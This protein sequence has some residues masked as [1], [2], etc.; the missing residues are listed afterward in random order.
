MS[1]AL[2]SGSERGGTQKNGNTNREKKGQ[3]G[4]LPTP[5]LFFT[6]ETK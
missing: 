3:F 5:D 1:V 6:G 4:R 2:Q